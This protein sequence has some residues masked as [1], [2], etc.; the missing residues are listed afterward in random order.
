MGARAWLERIAELWREGTRASFAVARADSDE[1][2]G[3][4]GLRLVDGNGQIGYWTLSPARG[5]GVATRALRLLARWAFDDVGLARLQLLTEPENEASQRVAEKAGFR[6]E[7]LLRDYIELKGR[8]ADGIMFAR[9][10][11]DP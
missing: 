8:R 11:D 1:L 9:L 4:I 3:S 5:Q 6:R 10:R 7:G 2:L